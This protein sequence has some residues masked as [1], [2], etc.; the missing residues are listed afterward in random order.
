MRQIFFATL[1]TLAA[2]A[3][4]AQQALWQSAPVT[5]PVIHGDNTVT[6]NV[7]APDATIVE[8]VGDFPDADGK[9]TVATMSRDS[10][11]VWSYTTPTPLTPELYCYNLRVNGLK[12]NDPANVHLLRDGSTVVNIFLIEDGRDGLYGVAD[13]PHGSVSKVWH[14]SPE[15]GIRR[16][17]TVYTPPGYADTTSSFPVLYLLHGMG[18]DENAWEE[19]GRATQIFDNLI[20]RGAM[21]PMVVVMP[22]GNAALEA[23][24]GQGSDGLTVP[25]FDLP[26]TMEGSFEAAFPEIVDYVD[27]HYRTVAQADSRA[28]AG[29][30]MGGFHAMHI[31]KAYPGTFGYVGLFSA[32][33]DPRN[34]P[35][36]D[37]YDDIDA[38]LKR[39]FDDGVQLYWIAI[40]SD[41]FLY[42]ENEAL[43]S[44][45]DSLALPYTY[46]ESSGGHSW[47]NW[48]IYLSEF[49]PLLFK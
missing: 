23:A 1:A 22:N 44:R 48:R 35:T 46:R 18:G 9:S 8:I 39:Q 17:M 37:V 13:M 33:V 32:A 21:R 29:L 16:R 41:D 11:G 25:R 3:T 49:L 42:K 45:L 4:S 7:K 34:K 31:S 30:S 36:W 26:K 10:L 43:R 5:S 12:V 38:R 47:Q 40:G 6:F 28:I 14:D 24:P 19:H 2:L 20:A 15:L 27:S